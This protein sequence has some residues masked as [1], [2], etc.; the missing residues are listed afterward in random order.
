MPCLL[1]GCNTY[2]AITSGG[3]CCVNIARLCHPASDVDQAA[4]EI[5]D[6]RRRAAQGSGVSGLGAAARPAVRLDRRTGT[7][8]AR[9]PFGASRRW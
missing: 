2:S 1:I 7:P 9:R 6:L 5:E 8:C 3:S 4:Q